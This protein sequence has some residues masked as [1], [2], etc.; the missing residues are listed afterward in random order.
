MNRLKLSNLGLDLFGARDAKAGDHLAQLLAGGNVSHADFAQLREVEEGQALGEELAVDDALAE[1]GDD[2]EADAAGEL[3][4]RG[5]DAAEVVRIDMLEAVAEDD[6][7]DALA[8]DLGALGAAVPD[9][10]GV[11]A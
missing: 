8:G 4:E 2:A 7:V 1:A 10:F 6:P 11:E 9:Q 3:V 5:A